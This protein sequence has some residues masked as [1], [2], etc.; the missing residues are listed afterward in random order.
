MC[1]PHKIKKIINKLIHDLFQERERENG[2]TGEKKIQR[3]ILLGIH[4]N[5]YCIDQK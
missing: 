4:M 2:V 1:S 3:L 5:I